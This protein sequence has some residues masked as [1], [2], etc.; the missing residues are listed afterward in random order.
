M[1]D[2]RH[3]LQSHKDKWNEKV[4]WDQASYSQRTA[5]SDY[6][7]LLPLKRQ[8]KAFYFVCQIVNHSIKIKKILLVMFKLLL[9]TNSLSWNH[10]LC[11]SGSTRMGYLKCVA[12]WN[13]FNMRKCQR[14]FHFVEKAIL[15]K[16]GSQAPVPF[17]GW[18]VFCHCLCAQLARTEWAELSEML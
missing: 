11:C 12:K 8:M 2:I 16:Y 13:I 10:H 14:I 1:T 18:K 17:L 15:T 3:L 7:F 9:L 5:T 6:F 4:S